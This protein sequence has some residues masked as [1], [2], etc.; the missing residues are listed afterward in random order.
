M[1]W[2]LPDAEHKIFE[3][4]PLDAVICQ[5]RFDTILKVHDR[6]PDFQDAIRSRFPG[7]QESEGI[8]FELTEGPPRQRMVRQ[9]RFTAKREPTIALL[10]DQA[11][12]LEYRDHQDR[13]TLLRDARLVSSALET[14]YSNVSPQRLG[15]RYVNRIELRQI[16]DD[17]GREVSWS[18]VLTPDFI[19]V[20]TGLADLTGSRFA[21]ELT[22]PLSPGEMTVRMGLLPL[23]GRTDV[24]FRL[25][26]DRYTEED[27]S[28]ADV[29]GLLGGFVDDIYKL[30]R[31]AAGPALIE[32]ME[33]K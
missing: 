12:S 33:A 26:V 28:I 19:A 18:D 27:F 9:H 24:G 23:P 10:G 30:F 17:L 3:R 6:V 4:N 29:D 16:G 31:A 32:W 1:T 25:D 5:L 11:V 2:Q 7:Y 20:P 15:L 14:V 13:A 21:S 22:S 8:M